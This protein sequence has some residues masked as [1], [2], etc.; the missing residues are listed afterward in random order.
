LCQ[1]ARQQIDGLACERASTTRPINYLLFGKSVKEIAWRTN[2]PKR[3]KS[4]L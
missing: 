4:V 1:S 3:K 2:L